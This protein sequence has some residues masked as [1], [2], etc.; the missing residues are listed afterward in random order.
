M[1]FYN[2]KSI[3]RA[4]HFVN[5]YLM[6]T[7]ELLA[8][9]ISRSIATRNLLD[10]NDLRFLAS[11]EMTENRTRNDETIRFLQDTLILKTRT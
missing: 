7:A 2:Y 3:G 1:F 10:A 9:V 11:L 8:N 6:T 5:D 4:V